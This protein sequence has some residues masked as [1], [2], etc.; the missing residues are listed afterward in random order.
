MLCGLAGA[1]V[2]ALQ[3]CRPACVWEVC[4]PNARL[5]GVSIGYA[6]EVP[7]HWDPV[8]TF[9]VD[10]YMLGHMRVH[11]CEHD[12]RLRSHVALENRVP[13]QSTCHD[14]PLPV[15]SKVGAYGVPC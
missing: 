2:R 13:Q 8:G 14:S 6:R 12:N 11:V 4:V 1:C 5:I 3:V 9:L 15:L 10:G 7:S